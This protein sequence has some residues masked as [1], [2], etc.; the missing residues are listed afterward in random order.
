VVIKDAGHAM[1]YDNPDDWAA[2]LI[3]IKDQTLVQ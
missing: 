1:M 3:A 2:A